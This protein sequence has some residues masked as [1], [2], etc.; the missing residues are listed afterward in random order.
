MVVTALREEAVR[1]RSD[2]SSPARQ[3]RQHSSSARG[4]DSSGSGWRRWRRRL[5]A[6][7][8]RWRRWLGQGKERRRGG[9]TRGGSDSGDSLGRRRWLGAEAMA[10]SGS[11]RGWV[12]GSLPRV[13]DDSDERA[14][15]R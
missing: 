1:G 9:S 6:R 8:R 3:W 10:G 15:R 5:G 11:A 4:N 7:R 13:G 2:G 12:G 14:K